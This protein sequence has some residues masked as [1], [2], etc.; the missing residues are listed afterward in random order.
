MEGKLPVT[1]LLSGSLFFTGITWASTLPYAG[2]VAVDV[3]GIDTG[4]YALLMTI[5]SLV[6]ALASVGLGYFSD[7]V[8]DRRLL[9]IGCAL[10]GAIGFGLIY[11]L[12]SPFGPLIGVPS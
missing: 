8:R 2:I 12:R 9:V 10:M 4:S 1:A 7:K 6:G 3:L 11:A 5:S